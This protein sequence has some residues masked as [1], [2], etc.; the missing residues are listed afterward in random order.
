MQSLPVPCLA[1][2]V[3]RTHLGLNQTILR[4]T[5]ASR[6][7]PQMSNTGLH[8]SSFM[9][10]LTITKKV[11]LDSST[12]AR[13]KRLAKRMHMTE[14]AVLRDALAQLDAGQ[15]RE[16]LVRQLQDL[17]GPEPPKETYSLR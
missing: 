7:G 16:R 6:A 9:A 3:I 15:D 14:S 10:G 4:G 1:G 12:A 17:L 2:F 5:V 13:L 11:R 8:Q